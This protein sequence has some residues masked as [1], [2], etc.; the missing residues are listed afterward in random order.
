MRPLAQTMKAL[1]GTNAGT[2]L[3][4]LVA[5]TSVAMGPW[6][7]TRTRFGRVIDNGN[8]TLGATAARRADLAAILNTAPASRANARDDEPPQ[9]TLD[10]VDR[11]RQARAGR[12]ELDGRP[13]HPVALKRRRAAA[14]RLR[15]KLPTSSPRSRTSRRRPGRHAAFARSPRP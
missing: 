14:A 6:P 5:S 10:V 13:T 4:R 12:R 11:W 8:V 2:D 1:R 9:Q 7:A 15:P 3:P